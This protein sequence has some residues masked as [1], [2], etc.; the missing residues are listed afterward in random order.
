M[1]HD[2]TFESARAVAD[3]QYPQR[4]ITDSGVPHVVEFSDTDVADVGRQPSIPPA[5]EDLHYI[6]ESS[7][8]LICIATMDGYF[9]KVN[10]AFETT[11]GW[12]TR[13]IRSK[14]FLDFVHPEDRDRTLASM[15]ALRHGQSL[16]RFE[17]RYLS[18]KG[19]Y[20]LLSWNAS[21]QDGKIYAVAR[22]VTT[23]PESPD[24][25]RQIT[26]GL[27]DWFESGDGSGSSFSNATKRAQKGVTW[28]KWI[29]AIVTT[30]FFAG[31]GYQ[32][33]F[34]NNATKED[35]QEHVR[36]DLAPVQMTLQEV[37]TSV[38]TLVVT[39]EKQAKAAK[40]EAELERKLRRLEAYRAE[41]QEALAEYTAT[42]A[43]GKRATRPRKT[44]PHLE[45]EADLAS[46]VAP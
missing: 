12:S 43:A 21:P 26:A 5:N 46:P 10:P 24:L 41:Y 40:A 42:R 23:S 31:V 16:R 11:L 34:T 45:L 8:E 20:R 17:N 32:Q 28:L 1:G 4:R 25:Q 15:E 2:A 7:H 30:V 33:F 22:D 9:T 27:K 19:E 38:D 39:G 3:P 13:Q 36:N 44:Q 35:I 37:K 6:F 18:A 14:P 29:G